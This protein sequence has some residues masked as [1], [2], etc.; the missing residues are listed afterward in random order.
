MKTLFVSLV[1]LLFAFFLGCESSVT[2]P[3][4]TMPTKLIGNAQQETFAFK[5]VLNATYPNV[6][7][8]KGLLWDPSHRLNSFAEIDGV[9]RYGFKK[10]SNESTAQI[11]IDIYK[12]GSD[13]TPDK[14]IKVDLYVDAALKSQCPLNNGPWTVKNTADEIITVNT[15]NQVVTYIQKSFR[16]K[17][18][19]CA[20]LN[21]VLKF[22]VNKSE[23]KLVSMELKLAMRL[24]PIIDQE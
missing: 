11:P 2:D 12:V 6:I 18:T 20:P 24:E 21:L 10:V 16:L 1:A 7:K 13:V 14:K 4:M 23:L 5:D 15:A 17:N 9:V 19:C 8:L 22:E 3:E